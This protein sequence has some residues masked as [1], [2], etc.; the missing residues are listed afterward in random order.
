MSYQ[1]PIEWPYGLSVFSASINAACAGPRGNC[2]QDET[3][4]LA[5]ISGAVVTITATGVTITWSLPS[6][7]PIAFYSFDLIFNSFETIT[8]AA[9][10]ATAIN[11]A[12]DAGRYIIAWRAE[13]GSSFSTFDFA[14][15]WL[16]LE[17]GAAMV[18][19][20]GVPV[21]HSGSVVVHTRD[22]VAILQ[23]PYEAAFAPDPTYRIITED[24]YIIIGEE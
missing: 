21:L 22:R 11:I 7:H 20:A 6:E 13:D 19:A 16:D 18:T 9:P 2:D 4:S 5:N 10:G 3:A 15:I 1:L 12:L 14:T 17:G 8:T 23:D 24:D